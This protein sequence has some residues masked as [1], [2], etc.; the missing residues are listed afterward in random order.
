MLLIDFFLWG[1]RLWELTNKEKVLSRK[2]SLKVSV[3]VYRNG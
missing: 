2:L 1:V 3:A